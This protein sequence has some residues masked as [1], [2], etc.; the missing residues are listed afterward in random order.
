MVNDPGAIVMF[1]RTRDRESAT[2][3]TGKCGC[4]SGFTGD[5]CQRLA[6][7]TA[8]SVSPSFQWTGCGFSPKSIAALAVGAAG[9]EPQRVAR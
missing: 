9:F 6:C 4:F 7:P 5:A 3:V 8:T 2:S 1:T